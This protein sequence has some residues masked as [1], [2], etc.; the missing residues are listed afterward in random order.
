MTGRRVVGALRVVLGEGL[1]VQK[2]PSPD[3]RPATAEGYRTGRRL[4]RRRMGTSASAS[5]VPSERQMCVSLLMPTCQCQ[6]W[7]REYACSAPALNS[8]SPK[9][10]TRAPAGKNGRTCSNGAIWV[11]APVHSAK[12]R[13]TIGANDLSYRGA[14]R[15]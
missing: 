7:S 13:R 8:A 11:S 6:P 10:V 2:R 15:S 3:G 5:D 1:L 4:A 12:S 14:R 9:N